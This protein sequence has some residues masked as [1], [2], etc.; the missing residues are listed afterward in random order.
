MAG[1]L[2]KVVRWDDAKHRVYIEYPLGFGIASPEVFACSDWSGVAPKKDWWGDTNEYHDMGFANSRGT[3]FSMIGYGQK[4]YNVKFTSRKA[5]FNT[6][7][8]CYSEFNNCKFVTNVGGPE[9]KVL[10]NNATLKNCQLLLAIP[11][12]LDG[13]GQ[14][15][16]LVPEGTFSDPLQAPFPFEGAQI[17]KSMAF[18]DFQGRWVRGINLTGGCAHEHVQNVTIP[19]AMFSVRITYL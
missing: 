16:G 2:V 19:P 7:T 13:T 11:P 6:N 4:F 17:S 1:S 18:V 15:S 14:V 8:C 9:L 5:R 10:S 3:P 12:D